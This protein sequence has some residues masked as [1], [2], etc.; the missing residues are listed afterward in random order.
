MRRQ[1]NGF[2]LI[3]LLVVIA[4]IAVLMGIL[5]PALQRVKKKAKGVMCR[6][7][8]KQWGTMFAMYVDDNNGKFNTRWSGPGPGRTHA[9]RWM[10]AMESFYNDAEEIRLCPFVKK[11]SNPDEVAGEDIWGAT[12]E[13]WGRIP[14]AQ[15][16]GGRTVGFYGSY[17]INGWAFVFGEDTLYG[18]SKLWSWGSPNVK[19]AASIPLFMDGYFWCGWPEEQDTPPATEDEQIR[20]DANAMN[21]F[22]INRHEGSINA[23]W[24]D[25][26][27]E[28]IKLKEMWEYKWHR[29]YNTAGP[30]TRAGGITELD[31]PDWM[32]QL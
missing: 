11:L 32:K 10:D 9:G 25:F 27:V 2:T 29:Q 14:D 12:F 21:R 18:K 28:P 22:C 19:G 16:G 17:G 13:G 30:W 6:S 5:M 24:F 8:L 31:W 7:N 1:K 23:L 4:I 15:S 3:E 20:T 26:H